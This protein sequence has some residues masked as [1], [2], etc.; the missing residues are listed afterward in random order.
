MIGFIRKFFVNKAGKLADYSQ[1]SFKL[2]SIFKVMDA[3]HKGRTDFLTILC[4]LS[5]IGSTLLVVTGINQ[6]READLT[7][8]LIRQQMD[9]Q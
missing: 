1:S 8:A 9:M 6:Y 5:L 7:S 4:V 3:N 2:V